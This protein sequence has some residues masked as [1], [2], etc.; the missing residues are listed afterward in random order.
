[1]GRLDGKVAFITGANSGVGQ[2]AVQTFL[3][4]GAKIAALDRKDDWISGWAEENRENVI[5]FKVDLKNADE[6]T[7]AVNKTVEVFGKLDIV[8]N[9]AGVLDH[10][11]PVG[12]CD[13]ALMED[14][15]GSNLYG[16]YN[17]TKAALPHF[18]KQGKGN[19]INIA[20]IAGW[21][22]WRGGTAYTM[23]KHGVIGLTKSTAWAYLPQGIRCNAI[24]P[25]GINTPM[26]NAGHIEAAKQSKMGYERYLMIK[27]LK[28]W[29]AEPIDIVNVGLF[30]ATDESRA[31]NGAEIHVD[32]GNSCA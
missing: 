2:C 25:S 1:M 6:V 22:G 30:L 18:L 7:A 21:H 31:I 8:F 26:L 28:P 17:T 9:I 24:C 19:I 14:V 11:L 20:S 5:F 16:C 23:S 15:M 13:D 29:N 32:Q 27:P 10:F 3:K 4:E 12:E